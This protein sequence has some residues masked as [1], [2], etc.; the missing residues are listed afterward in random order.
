VKERIV[1]VAH[2]ELIIER[3]VPIDT[4]YRV[5]GG[6]KRLARPRTVEDLRRCLE[7][8]PA[9]RVLGDG[10][11]LL[12][13][14]EGVQELVV[15]LSE[16]PMQAV[17]FEDGPRGPDTHIVAMAGANLPRLVTETVRRGLVG[18]EGLGG[19]PASL[20]GAAVMNAGG[21][22]GQIADVI[23]RI[24]A[25]DRRGREVTLERG[26]IGYSY[27]HSGLNHLLITCVEMVLVPGDKVGLRHR[28]K[29]I[30]AYKSG[31]QP[32]AANSAGCCFRNPTVPRELAL[33]RG[34]VKMNS[35]GH[36]GPEEHRGRKLG[37]E[38]ASKSVEAWS[39]LFSSPP[40]PPPSPSDISE[41][42]VSAGMLI[43]RAGCKG[44]RIGSAHVSTGHANF[45]VA[46]K[47][48][49]AGDVIALMREVQRR[50]A[51]AFG[52]QL[53]P[54]VVVWGAQEQRGTA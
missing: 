33:S 4:W 13:G 52:V 32:M 26:E 16:A 46:D 22:F 37:E 18:L 50:V 39:N 49:R 31:S 43:D 47:G 14:D 9:L 11:N 24:H 19:I 29:E 21:T 25:L 23:A 44:L 7:L 54:E 2:S 36:E 10:A 15:A 42:R 53:Q 8:D 6:A 1:A 40:S 3:D 51:E 38:V 28:L 5:G 27:R 45:L 20:G 48:G 35:E 41:I 30:M 17:R 34:W 12:V